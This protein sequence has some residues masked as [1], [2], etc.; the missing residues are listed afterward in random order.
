MPG[1][2]WVT[3]HIDP[4]HI[5]QRLPIV[6]VDFLS[7]SYRTIHIFQLQQAEGRLNFVHLAVDAGCDDGKLIREAK[8]LQVINTL[9][10]F[11]IGADNGPPSKVLNTFVAWKLSTERSPCFSTLPPSLVTPKA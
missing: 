11:G 2:Q 10:G 5:G 8:V 6:S 9:L 3:I 4:R 1:G 7:A